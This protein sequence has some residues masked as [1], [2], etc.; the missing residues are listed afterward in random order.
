MTLSLEQSKKTYDAKFYL[1]E[2]FPYLNLQE[3]SILLLMLAYFLKEIP[4]IR[5]LHYYTKLSFSV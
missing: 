1:D 3:F 2:D 5:I 4:I